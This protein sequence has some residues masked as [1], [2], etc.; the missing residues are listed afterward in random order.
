M[1]D[2]LY[3][4]KAL[5]ASRL[6]A[7]FLGEF[8]T[9]KVGELVPEMSEPEESTRGGAL[10]LQHVALKSPD[11]LSLV[12]ATVN[13]VARSASVRSFAFV[14]GM[15]E[16]RFG[17]PVPF[18]IEI[19]DDFV[20]RLTKLFE[21]QGIEASLGDDGGGSGGRAK[22]AAAVV[23]DGERR[24]GAAAYSPGSSDGDKGSGRVI[25]AVAIGV[26]LGAVAMWLMRQ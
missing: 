24:A 20:A 2:D 12:V 22:A 18:D 21:E 25:I 8:A 15:Y 3:T 19:Y 6:A 26:L 16:A 23:A 17:K 10:A 14:A 13:A 4:A 1:K 11:G 7:A 9:T 5:Q